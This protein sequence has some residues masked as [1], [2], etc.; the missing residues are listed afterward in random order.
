MPRSS[1]WRLYLFLFVCSLALLYGIGRK[2]TTHLEDMA[3]EEL[4]HYHQLI[5]SAA[6]AKLTQQS[7]ML[8]ILSRRLVNIGIDNVD[9]VKDAMDEV[10]LDYPA[11][12]A[13]SLSTTE[14]QVIFSSLSLDNTTLP[15]LLQSSNARETFQEML[16]KDGMVIGRT[17]FFSPINQWIIP[18]HH[19]IR[20]DTGNAIGV[21][22]AA[23]S[24]DSQFNP[25]KIGGLPEGLAISITKDKNSAN[26]YYPQYNYPPI[27]K[28]E[29]E[30]TAYYATPIPDD[31][32]VQAKQRIAAAANTDFATFQER[33]IAVHWIFEDPWKGTDDLDVIAYNKEFEIFIA[34]NRNHELV[35]KA[36]WAKWVQ[37]ASVFLIFNLALY[38][39]IR[40]FEQ[41]QKRS[42]A[43]LEH[44][45][46]H[47]Q[48]TNLPNRYYLEQQ[49]PN[50]KN[51]IAGGYAVV[52]LD[53]DNFKAINDYYGHATGDK[54]L[55]VLAARLEKNAPNHALAI[56]QGG[57]EFIILIPDDNAQ[58]IECYVRSLC[59]ELRES[60]HVDGLVF[61][62]TGSI[63]IAISQLPNDPLGELLKNA[64][65]AMYEAKRHCSEYAFF[66]GALKEISNE[67][68]QIEE[69]LHYA[70]DNGQMF[71]VYQPQIQA[72][73]RR[74]HGVE[75][76][77]RWAHP[78]MGLIPP[79]KFIP[80]A[81]SS[82]KINEIGD[83]IV[84]TALREMSE[85]RS[86]VSPFSVSINV[87]VRQLHN[88]GFCKL[89]RNKSIEYGICPTNI[90]IEITES[91][92]I[93]DFEQIKDILTEIKSYGFRISLDDFGTGYSSL[94]V[95]REL[96][97]DE[98]K[99]DKSFVQGVQAD[100]R[101][102]AFIDSIIGI[103]HSL[104]I[105]SVAEGLENMADVVSLSACGCD[106]FQ[107]YFFARPMKKQRLISYMDDFT[108]CDIPT[109]GRSKSLSLPVKESVNG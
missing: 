48:L 50:W 63:G 20:D 17:H 57:D 61:I 24:V 94:S 72:N 31:V 53:M 68:T 89:I 100:Q 11:F 103:G 41:V 38:H 18:L 30:K 22:S 97:I 56:R 88:F 69:A 104:G 13:C 51:Q 26:E 40:R 82:G 25:W 19:A 1:L 42:K 28:N 96:P 80:L 49:F 98:I 73:T 90:T 76:L 58:R 7:A 39:I 70:L 14:G 9:S 12:V 77:I 23:I 46:V 79:D 16:K 84:D 55:K 52:F 75:A 93:D 3:V 34:V 106:L 47:D 8:R 37:Y 99:I 107:G 109:S 74:L 5:H 10:L 15:N 32:V 105:P 85:I 44:Q 71:M 81:E 2:T 65:M 62:L 78:T 43:L 66:S 33:E 59:D 102:L 36:V 6:I 27:G 92:F 83:F 45:A 60:I 108:P 35:N 101:G 87:S 64:D 91:L 54:I 67:R 4:T 95:L 86:G 29:L 21:V